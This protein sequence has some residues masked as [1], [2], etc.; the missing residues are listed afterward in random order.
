VESQVAQLRLEVQTLRREVQ[1]LRE[2]VAGSTD[3]TG[4]GP[5]TTA[6]RG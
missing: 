2:T 3:A 4:V 6:S 1:T 5:P